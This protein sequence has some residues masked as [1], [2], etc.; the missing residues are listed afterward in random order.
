V[1]T[2]A[3]LA[4]LA[5]VT[6]ISVSGLAAVAVIPLLRGPRQA[7]TLQALVS[8]AAG[9]LVGDSLIHLLPHALQNRHGQQDQA[10]VWKGFLATLTVIL[11]FVLD[12]VLTLLG[13]AHTHDPPSKRSAK[14]GNQKRLEKYDKVEVEEELSL[15]SS[16]L[17]SIPPSAAQ[18]SDREKV[19][20]ARM[21]ILGDAVHNLADGLAIGAAFSLSLAAGLS[22]SL[23]VLCHELPHEVGDFALLVHSGMKVRTA[24]IANLLSSVFA[25]AGLAAGLLLGSTGQVSSWLL[26]ATT[27]VF[28]YVSLVSMM[29]ELRGPHSNLALNTAGMLTGAVLLLIIGLYEHDIVLWFG[30]QHNH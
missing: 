4:G 26:A 20:S 11:L 29:S 7:A 25:L 12:Q 17:S 9:T 21:V 6:V 5:S 24:V 18:C 19:S 22:T 10:A 30:E 15:G 1:G 16:E 14:P 28:L 27:G 2:S 13:H 3:W 8:L 23:A